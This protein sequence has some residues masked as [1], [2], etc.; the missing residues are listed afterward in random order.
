MSVMSP[1][2]SI[3]VT[4]FWFKSQNLLMSSQNEPKKILILRLTHFPII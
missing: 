4:K 1:N 3:L 2:L